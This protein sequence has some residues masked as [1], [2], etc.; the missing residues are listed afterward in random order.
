VD[1]HDDSDDDTWG[2][3]GAVKEEPEEEHSIFTNLL[4]DYG[5]HNSASSGGDVEAQHRWHVLEYLHNQLNDRNFPVP[6][7]L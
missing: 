1:D 2:T 6:S 3:W 7:S 5:G 4:Q